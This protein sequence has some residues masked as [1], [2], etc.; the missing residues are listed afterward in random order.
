MTV[1]C[2]IQ[3]NE[4]AGVQR[5]RRGR[6]GAFALEQRGDVGEATQ[7][8]GVRRQARMEI[9]DVQDREI[10]D[11]ALRKRDEARPEQTGD[12]I[13]TIALRPAS[14]DKRPLTNACVS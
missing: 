14:Y 2:L 8:V 3:S 6:R 12:Q 4:I 1:R 7:A 5:D 10:A 11:G 13:R 9:V